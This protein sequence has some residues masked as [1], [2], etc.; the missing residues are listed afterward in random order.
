[1]FRKTLGIYHL[2][3]LCGCCSDYL[4]SLTP[5]YPRE[6]LLSASFFGSPSPH[7]SLALQMKDAIMP[8]LMQ[9][10]EGTPCFVHAGEKTLRLA[11]LQCRLVW[12]YTRSLVVVLSSLQFFSVLCVTALHLYATIIV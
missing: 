1:M 8:T 5:L 2:P 4:A 3:V 9:T 10:V 12:W 11:P 6:D 7:H